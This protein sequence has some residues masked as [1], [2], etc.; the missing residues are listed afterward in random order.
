MTIMDDLLATVKAKGLQYDL[1]KILTLMYFSSHLRNEILLAQSATH[2]PSQAPPILPPAVVTF[3]SRTCGMA[4]NVVKCA[5]EQVKDIVWD[6][7]EFVETLLDPAMR[8]AVFS[9]YGLDLG[10]GMS[11]ISALNHFLKYFLSIITHHLSP[12]QYM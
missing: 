8:E 6:G 10:F 2:L 12:Y 3:L 5:W 7:N 1:T 9:K 4:E 11:S